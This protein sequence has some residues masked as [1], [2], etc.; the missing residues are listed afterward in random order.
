[1]DNYIY[2][3]NQDYAKNESFHVAKIRLQDIV[4]Q[5][6]FT[7]RPKILMIVKAY[8]DVKDDHDLYRAAIAKFNETN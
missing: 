5:D 1:V 2:A 7:N 3:R 4:I 6:M 8:T